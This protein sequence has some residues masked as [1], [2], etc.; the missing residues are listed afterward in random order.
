VLSP[1]T[2]DGGLENKD[3]GAEDPFKMLLKE[4]LA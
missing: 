4:A 1:K 3:D 2:I